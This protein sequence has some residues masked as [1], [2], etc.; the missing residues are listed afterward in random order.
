MSRSVRREWRPASP[1][2]ERSRRLP[3]LQQQGSV[4]G[5]SHPVAEP[6]LLYS[7]CAGAARVSRQGD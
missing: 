5:S 3:V 7:R 4:H 2:H 6:C 1:A